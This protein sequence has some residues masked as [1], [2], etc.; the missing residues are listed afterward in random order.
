M[1]PSV[2]EA[3]RAL[4]EI[5]AIKARAA[6]FQD[7]RA[8]SDQLLLW[9]AAHAI[10]FALSGLFPA[11]ILLIWLLLVPGSML[12]G[13]LLARRAASEIP[14]IG[15]RYMVLIGT[16][17]TYMVL[18]HVVMWPLTPEQGSMVAPLFVS[19]LYVMRGVQMRPR[20]LFIGLL[21]AALL[22]IGFLFFQPIFWWWMAVGYGG[23]FIVFGFWLRRL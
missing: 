19:A 14:G 17:F 6:G 22:M 18:V 10:G 4:R 11:F 20:Y 12:I 7:Y 5:D 1:P 23:S 15:W 9:G 2:E 8:E 13:R 3:A 16:I 21:L